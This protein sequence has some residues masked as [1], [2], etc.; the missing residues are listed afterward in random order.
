MCSCKCADVIAVQNYEIESLPTSGY[1][2]IHVLSRLSTTTAEY[3]QRFND[4]K[5]AAKREEDALAAGGFA[6]AEPAPAST[7][8]S[9]KAAAQDLTPTGNQLSDSAFINDGKAGTVLN[10]SGEDLEAR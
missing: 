1:V 6:P 9:L 10:G 4:S 7:E 5:M 2:L 8:T 3:Q